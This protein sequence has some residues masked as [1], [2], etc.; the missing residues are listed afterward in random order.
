M[1]FQRILDTQK[2]LSTQ[3]LR[4]MSLWELRMSTDDHR[5]HPV[6]LL[7]Y[8]CKNHICSYRYQQVS[9]SQM[10]NNIPTAVLKCSEGFICSRSAHLKSCFLGTFYNA[11]GRKKPSD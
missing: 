11:H 1:T 4:K 3:L 10:Q 9:S 6:I 7:L 2:I 5:M 8:K